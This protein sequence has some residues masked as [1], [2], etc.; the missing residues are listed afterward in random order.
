MRDAPRL[1]YDFRYGDPAF[2]EFPHEA[3]WRILAREARAST[4]TQLAY[5]EPAGSL[6]LREAQRLARAFR[7]PG[8]D[9][10]KFRPDTNAS[11]WR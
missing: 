4:R 9:L 5:G 7:Q 6:E 8:G 3:W 10:D 1:A 2:A 11:R